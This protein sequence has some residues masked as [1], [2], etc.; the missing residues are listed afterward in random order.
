MPH[1]DVNWSSS[2]Y[3]CS[4]RTYIRYVLEYLPSGSRTCRY[5]TVCFPLRYFAN[6]A[7]WNTSTSRSKGG[8]HFWSANAMCSL[9][10]FRDHW[11]A[12]L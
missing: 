4:D 1:N 7:H 9:L 2:N 5:W 8:Y 6:R 11:M 12:Q 3:Q 10:D